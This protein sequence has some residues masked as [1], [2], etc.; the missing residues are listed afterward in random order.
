[1]NF[2]KISNKSPGRPPLSSS[3][4]RTC[5]P[6]SALL[7]PAVLRL[8]P[9]LCRRRRATSCWI[10]PH[11]SSSPRPRSYLPPCCPAPSAPRLHRAPAGRHLIVVVE[12]PPWSPKP[13]SLVR[14]STTKASTFC[15]SAPVA[16]SRTPTAFPTAASSPF[17]LAT[18]A[19]RG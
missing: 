10:N 15:S 12:S 16:N 9:P 5:L 17:T 2:L 19:H 7:P 6:C 14:T 13:L 1:L 18:S 11:A 8:W 4:S 3:S